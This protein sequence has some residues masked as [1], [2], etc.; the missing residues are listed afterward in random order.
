MQNLLTQSYICRPYVSFYKPYN[1]I[2]GLEDDI[3]THYPPDDKN[4]PDTVNQLKAAIDE[5]VKDLQYNSSD[6]TE[7]FS[8]FMISLDFRK[9]RFYVLELKSKNYDA[10]RKSMIVKYIGLA[11][12]DKDFKIWNSH[13]AVNRDGRI[14]NLKTKRLLK[15]KKQSEGFIQIKLSDKKQKVVHHIVALAWIPNDLGYRYVHHKNGD[16][17]DNRVDNLYWSNDRVVSKSSSA[18]LLSST[19]SSMAMTSTTS[20]SAQPTISAMLSKQSK[21][22]KQKVKRLRDKKRK[23]ASLLLKNLTG[24]QRAKKV[25]EIDDKI[26][27]YETSK[28][29]KIAESYGDKNCWNDPKVLRNIRDEIHKLYNYTITQPARLKEFLKW[30]AQQAAE[31]KIKNIRPH[32]DIEATDQVIEIFQLRTIVRKN[33]VKWLKQ[34]AHWVDSVIK[35]QPKRKK[36]I[37]P[38]KFKNLWIWG[39]SNVGKSEHVIKRL[40]KQFP[41]WNLEKSTAIWNEPK[42]D[43]FFTLIDEAQNIEKKD[44]QKFKAISDSSSKFKPIRTFC[45]Y[46]L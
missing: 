32:D 30:C 26:I 36:G 39:P 46:F 12:D 22:Q 11:W 7:S 34:V 28:W 21:A 13:Y 33:E 4:D 19:S 3:S 45:M 9:F 29:I 40:Q 2:L 31:L 15:G 10:F 41:C 18:L 43:D 38:T 24:E 17:Q 5:Y 16:R 1:S 44:I 25:Q 8:E 14:F 6:L 35:Q 27:P 37:H 42:D 23:D 20:S